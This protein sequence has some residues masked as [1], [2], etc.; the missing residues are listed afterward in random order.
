MRVR[1]R[2]SLDSLGDRQ[3]R[4]RIETSRRSRRNNY[5]DGADRQRHEFQVQGDERSRVG[6]FR[7]ALLSERCD[8]TALMGASSHR[9]ALEMTESTPFSREDPNEKN[10][11]QDP[12]AAI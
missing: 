11:I 4:D 12:L 1:R 3:Q 5:G 9:L 10:R 2:Q 7:D 8:G 6:R